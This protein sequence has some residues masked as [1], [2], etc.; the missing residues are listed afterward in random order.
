M[1][2]DEGRN[3][4]LLLIAVEEHVRC[5][6]CKE[7]AQNNTSNGYSINHSILNVIHYTRQIALSEPPTLASPTSMYL[8]VY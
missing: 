6:A 1:D 7:Y 4:D 3:F 8:R 5:N 2:Y